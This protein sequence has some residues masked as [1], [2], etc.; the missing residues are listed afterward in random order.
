MSK[1]WILRVRV[2]AILQLGLALPVAVPTD[3]HVAPLLFFALLYRS[4]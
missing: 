4:R 2:L 3:A 1:G